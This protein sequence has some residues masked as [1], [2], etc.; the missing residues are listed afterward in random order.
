MAF[1]HVCSSS[2]PQ[3][4]AAK[5]LLQLNKEKTQAIASNAYTF[6]VS[7]LPQSWSSCD[8]SGLVGGPT[9][10]SAFANADIKQRLPHLLRRWR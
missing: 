1:N 5:A 4:I 8:K 6:L 9:Q 10:S 7:R 3:D 2:M